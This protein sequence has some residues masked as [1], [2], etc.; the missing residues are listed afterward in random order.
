MPRSRKLLLTTLVVGATSAVAGLGVF[1]AFTATTDNPGN[2]IASGT[3]TISDNDASTALYALT[4]QGPG[5]STQRC[6]E[7]KYTGSL[8]STVKLYRTGTL[9]N[10]TAFNL[11]V[12]RG[13]GA[14]TFGSCTGFVSAG[15]LYTGTLGGLGTSYAG[16][17]DAKGSS[18]AQN[19]IV[20]YRFTISVVDDPTPNAHA[21]VVTSGAHGFTWEAQNN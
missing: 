5:A 6:I 14:S 11:T 16:G 21:A 18:W 2:S 8:P 10:G 9:A 17:V 15:T 13:S 20:D 3:V 19:D 7:V 12:E 1:A 4:N